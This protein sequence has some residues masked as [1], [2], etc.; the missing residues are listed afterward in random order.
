MIAR[1]FPIALFVAVV[2]GCAGSESES[3]G[4]PIAVNTTKN[5]NYVMPLDDA[6]INGGYLLH[7]NLKIPSGQIVAIDYD[8]EGGGDACA[9]IHECSAGDRCGSDH[10]ERVVFNGKEATWWG[11][12][13]DGMTTDATLKFKIH[14]VRADPAT[15]P[16]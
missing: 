6:K 5:V 4:S 3:P 9:H 8:C 16:C 15:P 13:E 7:V 11:W 12:T 14:F 1:F 2:A 10:E